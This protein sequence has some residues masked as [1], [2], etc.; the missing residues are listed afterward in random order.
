MKRYVDLLKWAAESGGG[1]FVADDG[2]GGDGGGFAAENERAQ[3]HR[4]CA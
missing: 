4:A 1:E 2:E 3:V